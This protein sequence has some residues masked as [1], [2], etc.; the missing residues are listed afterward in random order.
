[1]DYTQGIFPANFPYLGVEHRSGSSAMRSEE[2]A[3]RESAATSG[4][5]EAG[6]NLRDRMVLMVFHFLGLDSV[7]RLFGAGGGGGEAGRDGNIY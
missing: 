6:F 1:M 3:S 4:W 5:K 2:L 7:I